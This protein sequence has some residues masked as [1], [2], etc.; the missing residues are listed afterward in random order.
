[1]NI[2]ENTPGLGLTE[3][4]QPAGQVLVVG[5]GGLIGSYAARQYAQAGWPVHGISR[6]TLPDVEWTHHSADLLDTQALTK[7]ISSTEGLKGTTHLVFAAYVEK[8][9]DVELIEANDALLISVLNGMRDAGTPLKHVTIYQGGKAYGHHLGFFN[10][11]AKESDPR[12]IGPHFYATQ[13]DILR[14]RAQQ[15]GFSFTALRPE[16]VTGYATGNPMNLLLVI[17]VYAAISKELGLPMR[18]PGTR[19]AYEVLYQTTDAELLARATMWAGSAESARNEIFNVNN[20]DQFRWSQLW[21]R[22][23]AHFGMEYAPSQ[24]MS[25]A[26][27]MPQLAHVWERLVKRHGLVDTPFEK[28]VGWGVGDF[29]FH[30]EADNI[31]STVKVRQ[32]GFADVLDTETRLLQLFDRL[33]ENK[34]LPPFK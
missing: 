34:V 10:T 2:S 33:V 23:A 6:R 9:T 21:P 26:E 25:L 27:T 1:M 22:F 16:G 11:P 20:G 12:L 5:D 14:E 7:L 18:F 19:A 30:H 13:E 3:L 24:Q 15:D 4:P 32:A 31:T 28:L 29:L 8:A 17:G